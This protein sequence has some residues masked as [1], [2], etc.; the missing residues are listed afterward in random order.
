MKF[1]KFKK[2]V[3]ATIGWAFGLTAFIVLMG[4]ANKRHNMRASAGLRVNIVEGNNNYFIESSDI[5]ELIDTRGRN[6]KGMPMNDINMP[7]LEK[8]VYTNPYVDRAEV[9]STIDGY[10]N[11]QVWQR[12]PV[13]RIINSENEH[14]YID[15]KGEFMPVTDKFSKNVVVA[16]GF[17]FDKFLQKSL[18]FASPF[19]GDSEQTPVL[20]QLY[21]VASVLE[22]DPFWQSQIEQIYVNENFEL[23]L[24]PR[25]GSQRILIGDTK[26]LDK[27][28]DNLLVFYKEGI[29]KTGWNNYSVI[30]LK[31]KDQVVCTKTN[32]N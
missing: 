14:Y 10:V 25:V 29:S 16:N 28:L 8:I 27:K 23:E 5:K 13:I 22:N 1:I 12:N 20:I 3:L 21:E 32:N 15:E 4:F 30:N 31:Y 17:I 24:I 26:D 18:A 11:I 2:G 19:P 6:L 9:Y 7:M